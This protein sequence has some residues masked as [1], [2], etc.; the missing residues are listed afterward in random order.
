M[1]FCFMN[2]KDN[3]R[4]KL[5]LW[6]QVPFKKKLKKETLEIDC[7][8]NLY[9]FQYKFEKK[10][11]KK[12]HKKSLFTNLHA[13]RKQISFFFF[14]CEEWVNLFKGALYHRITNLVG[15]WAFLLSTMAY[16]RGKNLFEKQRTES[17]NFQLSLIF[18]N[19]P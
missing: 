7:I 15:G 6:P 18:T 13:L 16:R 1:P 2:R 8:G 19:V 12:E 4:Q 17:R 9:L 11:E 3:F 10:I 5:L 14:F